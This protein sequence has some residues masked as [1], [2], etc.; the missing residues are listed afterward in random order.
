M[1]LANL[2]EP[3]TLTENIFVYKIVAR[4]DAYHDKPFRSLY[5]PQVRMP[6]QHDGYDYGQVYL[7]PLYKKL[8]SRFPGFYCYPTKEIVIS[9]AQDI[10]QY[11]TLWLKILKC[12]IPAGTEVIFGKDLRHAPALLTP[13][14]ITCSLHKI[15]K[16]SRLI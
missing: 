7:Y 10:N 2:T 9:I 3:K 4:E 12:F 15:P 16:G 8:T 5:R 6:Q 1:C 14:L 13:T 11:T